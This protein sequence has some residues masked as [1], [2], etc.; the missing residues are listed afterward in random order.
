[1]EANSADVWVQIRVVDR[2]EES[3]LAA[4]GLIRQTVWLN[5]KG[6]DEM[7]T[8]GGASIITV[9]VPIVIIG[10]RFDSFHLDRY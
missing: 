3:E 9:S 8:M 5:R 1:M 4:D 6:A 7:F 2:N 10:R